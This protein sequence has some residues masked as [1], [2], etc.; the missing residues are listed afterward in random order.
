MENM[1]AITKIMKIK[2]FLFICLFCIISAVY[3]Q[4]VVSL[5]PLYTEQD[6]VLIPGIEGLWSVPF[7]VFSQL[8]DN[9]TKLP[10]G[11]EQ[12]LIDLAAFSSDTLFTIDEHGDISATF[13]GG[14]TLKDR[15]PQ[16]GKEIKFNAI[17][18]NSKLNTIIA[19]GENNAVYRSEDMG[20]TWLS[21][22]GVADAPYSLNAITNDGGNYDA[23][24]V[25]A[26]GQKGSVLKS[27]NDG[28][29]WE[30]KELNIGANQDLKFVSF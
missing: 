14:N 26:V 15:N 27:V 11:T 1:Y 12:T 19:V 29:S 18:I 3:S 4:K 24:V 16:T 30:K 7:S 22:P 25:Y 28:L 10:S 13:D 23:S 6:A 21:L 8:P 20:E 17:R 5:H 9:W 2:F